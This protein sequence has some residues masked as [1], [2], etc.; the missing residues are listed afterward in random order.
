VPALS[1][2]D[3]REN[4][5]FR[6]HEQE[7]EVMKFS[8]EIV[9]RG[10]SLERIRTIYFSQEFD[11][12]V[13][14]AANLV[15]RRQIEHEQEPSGVERTRTHVVP[16]IGLPGPVQKLLRGQV[17]SYDEVLIYDP[18]QKA[19]S[20]SIRSLAGKTVQVN[21]QVRFLEEPSAVRL[22]FEGEAR[23][24]VFGLGGML[25]RLLVREVTERYAQAQSVLQAFI[26]R[27]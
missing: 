24:H 18:T 11:D 12:A 4:V 13:A 5:L 25:E 8:V 2:H 26:D 23:I 17:I 21:G 20:F 19:A 6:R 14:Q 22:R 10:A 15:E 1:G 3:A 16:R 9:G 7:R 27:G